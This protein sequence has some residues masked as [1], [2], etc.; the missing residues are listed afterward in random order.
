MKKDSVEK[1]YDVEKEILEI[2]KENP[3]LVKKVMGQNQEK[4]MKENFTSEKKNEVEL[5]IFRI[6]CEDPKFV[7]R[8]IDSATAGVK[9]FAD[10]Q[11]DKFTK[12][13]YATTELLDENK[14]KT[15]GRFP[16]SYFLEL[17]KPILGDTLW[18][19]CEIA[20]LNRE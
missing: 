10:N 16:R 5:L 12:L 4:I 1:I 18:F 7:K 15:I 9:T 11:S 19:K 2:L 14:N 6:C 3:N 13:A 17:I 8:A 20:N